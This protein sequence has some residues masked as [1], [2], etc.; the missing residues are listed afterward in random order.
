MVQGD[1]LQRGMVHKGSV[2]VV[3]LMFSIICVSIGLVGGTSVGGGPNI[4]IPTP[5]TNNSF[6]SQAPQQNPV[7]VSGNY[8]PADSVKTSSCQC[9]QSSFEE[10]FCKDP[11]EVCEKNGGT[12]RVAPP[13]SNDASYCMYSSSS[14]VYQQKLNDTSCVIGCVQ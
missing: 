9:Q 5:V 3:A 12:L 7:N 6:V 8:C 11:N 1:L 14:S 13:G 2:Y 10:A 4:T